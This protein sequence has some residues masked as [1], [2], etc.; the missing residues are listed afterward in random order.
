MEMSDKHGPRVAD[1]LTKDTRV[2][3][4]EFRELEPDVKRIDIRQSQDGVLDDQ[5]AAARSEVARFLKP[6]DFPG[7]ASQLVA[8]AK[9]AFATDEIIDLLETLPDQLFENMQDVWVALGGDVEQTHA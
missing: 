6:S 4:E 3:H 9:E 1:D 7:R 5:E 8:A 2:G